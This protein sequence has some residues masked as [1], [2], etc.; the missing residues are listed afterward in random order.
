[1]GPGATS[2]R[3]RPDGQRLD[4]GLPPGAL[5]HCAPHAGARTRRDPRHRLHAAGGVLRLA[6]GRSSA[7]RVGK[8]VYSFKKASKGQDFVDVKPER[9]LRA[10]RERD[11]RRVP[12][13]LTEAHATAPTGARTSNSGTPM[14][15]DSRSRRSR[16][17]SAVRRCA[18]SAARLAQRS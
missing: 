7:T 3:E 10:P 18:S 6:D 9:T 2:G 16:V 17:V 5:L 15:Q 13:E 12:E 14:M 8:F 11:G 1:M 4:A